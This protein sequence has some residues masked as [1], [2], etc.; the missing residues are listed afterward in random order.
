M[1]GMKFGITPINFGP[2]SYPEKMARV[3]EAAEEVG[4]DSVWVGDHPFLSEKQKNMPP[5]LR[6]LDPIAALA[7]VAG[8]TRK[9]LLG[10]G[11]LLLPQFNPVIV[12]KQLASLDVLSNGRLVVGIGVGWSDHEFE[13]LG[14]P[15]SDRG[16]R[17]DDYLKAI[18]VLWSEDRP[19][20]HG[21]YVSFDKLQSYPHAVQRPHP[22]IVV[23]GGSFAAFRRAVESGNGWFGY[24][25]NLKDTKRCIEGL[26]KASKKYSRPKA[27]G[28]LEISIAPSV[29]IDK[30]TA[31]QFAD[32]GV[33]RLILIL[34]ERG[35]LPA[36]EH[37]VAE[38]GSTLVG[39]V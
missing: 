24:A 14:L 11:I 25:M 13:V 19:A 33:D 39:Q 23:G 32:L 2:N 4:F 9:V 6:I 20:Y 21:Q 15:F 28:E 29:P 12:A 31:R 34:P 16:R 36:M 38:A 1:T 26:R 7:F 37:F 5:S 17:A 8:Q 27:L 35:D 30:A 22:P 3:A 10:T 18:E